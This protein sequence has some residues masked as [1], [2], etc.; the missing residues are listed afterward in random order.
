M[1]AL[2][3]AAGSGKR[4]PKISSKIPK[5]L[6]KIGNKEIIKRQLQLMKDNNIKKIGM[7]VGFKSNK[8]N[9][10]NIEYFE[11]TNYKNNDQLDSLFY[12]KKFFND[13]IIV[14]FSDIIYENNMLK[15]LMKSK[16]KI[17]INILKNW[18]KNYIKRF[19][20]P[21]SQADK[22]MINKNKVIKIGK[23]IS[24]KET[25]GEFIGMFKISKEFC[26]NFIK[27]YENIKK[28]NKNK[29]LQM[30]DLF[31]FMIKKKIDINYCSV[32]GKYIEIDTFNDFNL[33]QQMFKK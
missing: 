14:T 26:K 15:S 29:K 10:K 30:N 28:Q 8:I 6:I 33:A 13:D 4:I 32:K 31:Q 23:K 7:V 11:N 22:V 18:K 3:I 21:H 24:M 9:I 19:D 17:T 20:H 27:S 1:K 2:I 25:N 12:A 5:C 16:G